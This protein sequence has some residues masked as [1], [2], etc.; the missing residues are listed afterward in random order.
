MKKKDLVDQ[1]VSEI[2]TGKVRTLGIYGHGASGKST[3]AQ[4]LYQALDSTTV[5][6]LETDPYITS[7]RHLVVPKELFEKTICFYTDE[8]TELKRRLAR[9][10][11]VRNRDA[12]FILA[13][14]QMRREQYL[15][16]Y[17]ETESKADILVDQSEDK[18]DV[19]RT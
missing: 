17:K 9:D 15:R 8:E 6:L 18:F 5:N 2:E 11:T 3:F 4:E 16:Y 19:K 12:S 1:L 10:T 13:S 14:H 7:G